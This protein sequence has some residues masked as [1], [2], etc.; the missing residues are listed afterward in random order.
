MCALGVIGAL[1]LN[2]SLVTELLNFGGLVGFMCVN[3]SV[4]VYY[5]V[6]KK[7]KK[8]FLNLLIPGLGFVVC[9][10]LWINLST[11]AL[12]IGFTWLSLGVVYGIILAKLSKKKLPLLNDM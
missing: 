12:T 6:K 11:F 3:L 1:T 9:F 5:F 7:E 8:V 2:I 10:Y 4:I